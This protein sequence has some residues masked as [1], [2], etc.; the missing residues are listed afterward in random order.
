VIGDPSP[1]YR[2]LED[3]HSPR[4]FPQD[5]I[6][7]PWLTQQLSASTYSQV[8][9]GLEPTGCY[10]E[11]W[12]Y[13]IAH[14]LDS[15]VELRFLNPYQTKQKRKELQN[16]RHRKSDPIDVAAIAHCLRDNLGQP[17]RLL[18]TSASRFG[19]WAAAFRRVHRE[20]QC[21]Q[22][23]LL[24][25]VD[26]LWPG[27]LIDV[28]TFCAAHPQL[29]AP[30]PLVLSRPLERELIQLILTHAPNPYDWLNL[31]VDAIQAFFRSHD[32]RCGP[33][34]AQRVYDIAHEALLL[35]TDLTECL[36]QQLQH[37]WLRYQALHAEMERLRQE[38]DTLVPSSPAAVLTTVPGIRAFLAAGYLAYVVD[39]DRFEHADQVWSLA[40]F[41]PAQDQSGDA[42]RVGKITR[43]G[44][45][46]LRQ[47]L[48]SIGLNTSQHCPAI[49]RAK[50]RALQHGKGRVGAV[51][52][53]AHLA[54]RLCFHLLRNQVAYDPERMR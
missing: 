47:V 9:V 45:P 51:I 49:G 38:A 34:T 44:H 53:A 7:P 29:P 22:M 35:P 19:V 41:D 23:N 36:A 20:Q 14:D 4:H 15:L 43:R 42:H 31:A 5:L 8:V 48:Y 27:A 30:K 46:G 16:G 54:N 11:P 24:S 3:T 28:K 17:A 39:P 13:A 1:V 12:A 40:G 26:R 33:T 25:Q 32:L 6:L 37:D 18:E 21:L 50:A 10:H 52:H 2:Q